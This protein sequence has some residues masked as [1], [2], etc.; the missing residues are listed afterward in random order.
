MWTAPQPPAGGKNGDY[1]LGWGVG[2]FEGLKVVAHDGGQQGT[3]TLILLAPE[4]GEGVV[5]LM[6]LDNADAGAL[7]DAIL[8]I[9]LAQ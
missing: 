8:K 6:N 5:V 1:A 3:S 9:L 2:E 4:R 7:G